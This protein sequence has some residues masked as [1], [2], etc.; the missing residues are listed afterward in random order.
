MENNTS[1]NWND[2][3]LNES[4]NYIKKFGIEVTAEQV[5][6]KT[7]KVDIVFA[8]NIICYLLFCRRKFTLYSV[9][10]IINKDHATVLHATRFGDK[11][12]QQS[13][14][15]IEWWKEITCRINADTSF[16]TTDIVRQI[17]Y[18]EEMISFLKKKKSNKKLF[19][20][21]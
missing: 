11:N 7:R 2:V 5:R 17:K 19:T 18:H 4:I 6:S 21:I 20:Y 16:G 13:K 10:A 15:Y 8:R 3:Y 1:L 9:A 14:V 12:R